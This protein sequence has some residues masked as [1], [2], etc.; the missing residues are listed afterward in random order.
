MTFSNCLIVRCPYGGITGL[1]RTKACE[2]YSETTDIDRYHAINVWKSQAYVNG[3][4]PNTVYGKEKQHELTK[5][6][7]NAGNENH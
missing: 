6:Q 4:D 3:T 5:V 1:C 2:Y 7:Q